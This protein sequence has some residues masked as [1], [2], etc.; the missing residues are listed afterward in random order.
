[1]KE[2]TR[3][4]W[5]LVQTDF[6]STRRTVRD[7][8]LQQVCKQETSY[9]W[10]TRLLPSD[11]AIFLYFSLFNFLHVPLATQ[12][13]HWW[14][15]N[16]SRNN[17]TPRGNSRDEGKAVRDRLFAAFLRHTPITTLS[18]WS[19]LWHPSPLPAQQQ[20][21]E[22]LLESRQE[23]AAIGQWQQHSARR[24]TCH[25]CVGWSRSPISATAAHCRAA[26]Q[27]CQRMPHRYCKVA[28]CLHLHSMAAMETLESSHKCSAKYQHQTRKLILVR[29]GLYW[30]RIYNG[31]LTWYQ[32]K[33]TETYFYL[34]SSK[35]GLDSL[36]SEIVTWVLLT[37]LSPMG[38][39]GH[40]SHCKSAATFP[41]I[42]SVIFK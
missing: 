9:V 24:C 4:V 12:S 1:M 26:A 8:Y 25:V 30:G 16:H 20:E 14:Q 36:S 21:P 28:C 11:T 13:N 3:I 39:E 19:H 33:S 10:V 37:Q 31:V 42:L 27:R 32:L 40:I 6:C 17:G 38:L 29:N 34:N 2:M 22:G 35:H 41:L 18:T 15:F 23:Q 5:S 7:R